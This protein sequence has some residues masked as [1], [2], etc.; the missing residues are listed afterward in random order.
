MHSFQS[1]VLIVSPICAHLTHL[2]SMLSLYIR[3]GDP[4]SVSADFALGKDAP[5]AKK[6]GGE[7]SLLG[8]PRV[9]SAIKLLLCPNHALLDFQVA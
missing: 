3:S 9:K 8:I 2:P 4:R 5:K 7:G 1:P 6:A